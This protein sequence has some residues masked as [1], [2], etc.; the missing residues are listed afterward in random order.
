[1]GVPSFGTGGNLLG[2]PA[3]SV[4]GMPP[5]PM[6]QS[7]SSAGF[8]PGLL[9]PSQGNPP[10]PPQFAQQA[11]SMPQAPQMPQT[12]TPTPMAPQMAPQPTVGMP[13]GPTET[14]HILKALTSRLASLTKGEEM[15]RGQA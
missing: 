15:S 5:G 3:S 14:M 12:P 2:A 4:M 10:P 9:P 6:Q 1:M 8:T 7:P 13:P 11:S